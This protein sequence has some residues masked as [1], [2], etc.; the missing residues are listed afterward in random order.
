[1]FVG[2]VMVGW[3]R[4]ACLLVG[5]KGSMKRDRHT[6]THTEKMNTHS[7]SCS[8]VG[9]GGGGGGKKHEER[10]GLGKGGGG[11]GG[12]K[13]ERKK[14]N[15]HTSIQLSFL[16]RSAGGVGGGG[17]GG[18]IPAEYKQICALLVHRCLRQICTCVHFGQLHISLATNKL[19]T[20]KHAIKMNKITHKLMF[21]KNGKALLLITAGGKKRR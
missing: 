4:Y 20:P 11:G 19:H 9:G 1:M 12:A 21:D 17:G 10:D 14:M 6:H 2:G 16:S 13:E 5:G 18:L 15:T 3:R 7:Y 8:F